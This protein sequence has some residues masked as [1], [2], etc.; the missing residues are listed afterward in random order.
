MNFTHTEDRRMLADSLDRFVAEQYAFDVRDRIAASPEGMD[1]DLWRRFA[2]LGAVGAL[3]G[4]AD[5]G[6]RRRAASTSRSSSRRSAAAWWSSPSSPP[7]S[8]AA[9]SRGRQRGAEGAARRH[10]RRQPHR[11][12][13]A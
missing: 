10:P 4:E 5:G 6:L 13:G 12:A 8:P 3:F 1:A 9:P 2:E 11:R 7:C